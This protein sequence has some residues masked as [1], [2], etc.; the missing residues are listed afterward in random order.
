MLSAVTA[1]DAPFGIKIPDKDDN[2]F[3]MDKALLALDAA[4]TTAGIPFER[5]QLP[6]LGVGRI[7]GIPATRIWIGAKS[8]PIEP[9]KRA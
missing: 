1:L 5:G 6:P 9:E 3:P 4:L 2:R 7:L 8:M